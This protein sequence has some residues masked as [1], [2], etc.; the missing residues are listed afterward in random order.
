[1]AIQHQPPSISMSQQS[2]STHNNPSAGTTSNNGNS[3]RRFWKHICKPFLQ[4]YAK[5]LWNTLLRLISFNKKS[6]KSNSAGQS[7]SA[8][9]RRGSSHYTH[10]D[11]RSGSV[12]ALPTIPE[13]SPTGSMHGRDDERASGELRNAK[14]PE[15]IMK[16]GSIDGLLRQREGE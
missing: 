8:S 15:G 16:K 6:V 4:R 14:G 11:Q 5:P 2:E 12:P 10:V 3:P 13:E 9:S 1:M 7:S